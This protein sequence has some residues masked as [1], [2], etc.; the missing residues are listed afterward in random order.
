M[1]LK[2]SGTE[3][4]FSKI[5][6]KAAFL[7][8]YFCGLDASLNFGASSLLALLLHKLSNLLFLQLTF[9][10]ELLFGS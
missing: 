7:L 6:F 1:E 3:F 9:L 5:F 2:T 10:L 4:C 8:A